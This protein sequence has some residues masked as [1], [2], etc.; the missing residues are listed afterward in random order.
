MLPTASALPL[1][2]KH[3]TWRAGFTCPWPFTWRRHQRKSLCSNPYLNVFDEIQ[4]VHQLYPDVA[5][6]TLLRMATLSGAE[7]LD[8]ETE[9]GSLAPGKSADLVVLRLPDQDVLDPYELL[10]ASSS[11]VEAV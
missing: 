9:T 2:L 10:L 11:T 1:S 8:W 7:A 4:Y 6:D 5:G 3:A